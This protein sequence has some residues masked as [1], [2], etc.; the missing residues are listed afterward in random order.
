M[1]W[2]L[3]E[4]EKARE[5]LELAYQDGIK[6]HNILSVQMSLMNLA[7]T[8]AEMQ[9]YESALE[10]YNKAEV[11]A[12]EQDFR[13]QHSNILANKARLQSNLGNHTEA[14]RIYKEALAVVENYN[15]A[16]QLPNL[17]TLQAQTYIEL[18]EHDR[19]ISILNEAIPLAKKNEAK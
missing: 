11:I 13:Y 7:E 9:Q 12:R 8:E 16:T 14:L 15:L 6:N 4:P 2:A 1:Y 17:L 10:K 18:K 19:A 3:H 5:Y